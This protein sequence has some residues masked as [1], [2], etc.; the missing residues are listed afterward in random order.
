MIELIEISHDDKFYTYELK[1]SYKEALLIER[2]SREAGMSVNDWIVSILETTISNK[3]DLFC[4]IKAARADRLPENKTG[5]PFLSCN[6][7]AGIYYK[8]DLGHEWFGKGVVTGITVSDDNEPLYNIRLHDYKNSNISK[9]ITGV[10]ESDCYAV[11]Y[12]NRKD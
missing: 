6:M 12:L 3:K 5:K 11:D 1:T 9:L 2:Y 10:R 8:D 7:I 4:L